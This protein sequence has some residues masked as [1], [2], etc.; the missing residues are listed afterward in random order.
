MGLAGGQQ[1]AAVVL[2]NFLVDANRFYSLATR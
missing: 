1:C 2:G